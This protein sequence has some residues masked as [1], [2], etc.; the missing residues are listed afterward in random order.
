VFAQILNEYDAR[1]AT[2]VLNLLRS[3]GLRC[4]L[5]GGLAIR[6]HLLTRG[7]AARPRRLNDVDLVVTSF[8]SIP[9]S[10]AGAFLLNHVHPDATDGRTLLQLVDEARALRI[11][12]F[13][14]LGNTLARAVRCGEPT[15][16][17]AVVSLEDLAARNTA[18]ICGRL[19]RGRTIDR[20]H[21]R[22]F[23]AL[24]GIGQPDLLDAAWQDHRQGLPG[25]IDT[26][27]RTA[28]RL[29]D[30]RP[31]LVVVEEYSAAP[32]PCARCRPCGPF[33]SAPRERIV[34]I[35][36]YC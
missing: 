5:T 8:A 22:A 27:E 16:E 6:A 7:R 1:R 34:E 33:I 32:T 2:E 17:L 11:D 24:R 14:E 20:K 29:I 21:V 30:E 3:Q 26:A 10:L 4:A 13:L 23:R 12:L 28:M 31:N 19:G 35:L 36:G 9:D 25:S 15:G 18:L